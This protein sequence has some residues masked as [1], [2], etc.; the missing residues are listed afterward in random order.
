MPYFLSALIV[1]VLLS[2]WR[3]MHAL[4]HLLPRSIWITVDLLAKENSA[5]K[6]LQ[7]LKD[8]GGSVVVSTSPKMAHGWSNWTLMGV[9]FSIR[10]INKSVPVV[11]YLL[12]M[13]FVALSAEKF[14]LTW[15]VIRKTHGEC[16]CLRQR[17]TTNWEMMWLPRQTSDRGLTIDRR[18][19]RLSTPSAAEI[20]HLWLL[21]C[22]ALISSK[23][24]GLR[25]G[26]C[27]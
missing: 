14:H 5:S 1:D 11:G 17:I 18:M 4:C 25:E 26:A 21:P 24:L 16:V 15:R 20:R 27:V 8:S 13:S 22:Q 2:E 7:G 10:R 23:E 3:Y 6:S 19:G 12:L 9:W